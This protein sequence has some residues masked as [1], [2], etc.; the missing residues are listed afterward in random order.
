MADL[1]SAFLVI[2]RSA[3]SVVVVGMGVLEDSIKVSPLGL[4]L[5]LALMASGCRR[6][7]SNFILLDVGAE[8]ARDPWTRRL[9]AHCLRTATHVSVRD[10]LSYRVARTAAPERPI[11]VAPDLVFAHP[12]VVTQRPTP[13]RIVVGVISAEHS[14][15]ARGSQYEEKM[16]H[17]IQ[18][19]QRRGLEVVLVGGD[20]TDGPAA[21]S[22][23][24]RAAL[25]DPESR[26]PRVS[27]V[28][29]YAELV[30]I[31]GTAE[32]VVAS[33]FHNLVAAIR[34]GRP[35]L[36]IGYAPKCEQLL[37]TVGLS[38]YSF[39]LENFDVTSVDLAVGEM[40]D[41]SEELS[42]LVRGRSRCFAGKVEDLMAQLAEVLNVA[43]PRRAEGRRGHPV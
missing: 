43:V 24:D 30:A 23:A 18:G 26:R 41:R 29:D 4:P 14:L 9:F 17:L 39:D 28:D 10:D 1:S 16:I 40:L 5:L 37:D 34:A 6:A 38:S 25:L 8:F 35:V 7:G 2:P 11:P 32:V 31:I 20:A 21:H 12:V 33:R 22:I 36:S 13:R 3:D 27:I 15:G 42:R 19:L